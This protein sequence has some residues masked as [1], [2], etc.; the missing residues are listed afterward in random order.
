MKDLI[1]SQYKLEQEAKEIAMMALSEHKE[2]GSDA[3]AMMHQIINNHQSVIYTYRATILCV[4]CDTNN[5]E[6]QLDEIDYKAMSFGDYARKLAYAVLL[7][8][9][10]NQ[11]NEVTA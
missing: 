3:S 11:Y 6:A 4:N 7:D 1:D 9:T 2:Y 5:G 10:I 8:A